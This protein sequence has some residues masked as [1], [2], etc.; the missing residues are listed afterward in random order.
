MKMADFDFNFYFFHDNSVERLKKKIQIKNS[1]PQNIFHR[2]R[3]FKQ[4]ILHMNIS[5][6][7]KVSSHTHKETGVILEIVQIGAE[8]YK[9]EPVCI[10]NCWLKGTTGSS[11]F[12]LFLWLIGIFFFDILNVHILNL[13]I[14]IG[15]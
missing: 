9:F 1:T 14:T 3:I 10:N 6:Y 13:Q 11:C 5:V 8:V 4:A 12:L 2:A 7:S 15:H